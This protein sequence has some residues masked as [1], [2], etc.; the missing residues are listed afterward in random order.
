MTRCGPNRLVAVAS[1]T[2]FASGCGEGPD[3]T[4]EPMS[5]RD[6]AGVRVVENVENQWPIGVPWEVSSDPIWTAG[7]AG[8]RC[9]LGVERPALYGLSRGRD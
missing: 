9:D 1:L 8:R 2:I 5:V 7:T 4:A 6:S 3:R